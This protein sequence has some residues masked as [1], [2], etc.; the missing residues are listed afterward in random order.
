M[1]LRLRL[2]PREEREA[3]PEKIYLC[4][5][6]GKGGNHE[7][8]LLEQEILKGDGIPTGDWQEVEVVL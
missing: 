6:T 1:K 4:A 8:V 7:P 2:V 5:M 3:N